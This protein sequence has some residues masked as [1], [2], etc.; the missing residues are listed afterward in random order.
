MSKRKKSKDEKSLLI[1]RYVFAGF[2]ALIIFS[3]GLLLGILLDLSRARWAQ[4]VLDEQQSNL[5]SLNLQNQLIMLLKNN[6]TENCESL[7]ALLTNAVL[8]LNKALDKLLEYR[9]NARID[10]DKS[11]IIE[12]Q[13]LLANIRYWIIARQYKAECRPGDLVT[14]LYF[15]NMD[16]KK[17]PDQGVILT[18]YKKLFGERLLVFPINTDLIKI[19]P[20]IKILESYYNI[21]AY[22]SIVIEDKTYVGIVDKDTLGRLICESFLEPQPECEEILKGEYPE[23]NS[24]SEE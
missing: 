11:R 18:Y 12:R 10:P 6:K 23:I 22:P 24:T 7:Q 17:C 5:V 4:E 19:E 21:G 3:L 20:S 8:D 15:F 14:I 16:C 9:E 13:Y 1:Y 2:V